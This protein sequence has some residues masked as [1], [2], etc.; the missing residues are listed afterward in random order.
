MPQWLPNWMCL[1]VAGAY[2]GYLEAAREA[3]QRINDIFEHGL[4]L[5][6]V[7]DA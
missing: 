2:L 4:R 1:A 6:G 3:G 5:A 7:P